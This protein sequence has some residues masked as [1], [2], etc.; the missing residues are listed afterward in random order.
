MEMI[1][2]YFFLVVA[3]LFLSVQP[4][5]IPGVKTVLANN[6]LVPRTKSDFSQ[7]NQTARW[8]AGHPKEWGSEDYHYEISPPDPEDNFN[9]AIAEDERVLALSNQTH[10]KLIDLEKNTTASIFSLNVPEKKFV[11]ALSL[12]TAADGGYNLFYGFGTYVYDTASTIF[13]Q[14]LGSDLQPMGDIIT[15]QG[16]IGAISKQGRLA[17]LDGYVY[18]LSTTN[19]TPVA[20][21]MGQTYQTG[22]SFGPDGVY[23][24][25]VNWQAQTADLWNSTS[26]EKIFAFPLTNSQNWATSISPNGDYVA[27]GLGSAANKVQIY[28]LRNLTA[29]PIEIKD[30]NNWPRFVEWS[31]TS[32]QVAIGDVPRLRVYDVPSKEIAQTWE[33][34]G[35]EGTYQ[36]PPTG[37]S[38]S[39]SGFVY[40]R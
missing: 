13:R 1:S 17:T 26:G 20:T 21:L 3:S 10:A 9:S 39:L 33:V 31:P 35:Y 36:F 40:F 5:A 29:A 11:V 2:T 23:L 8:A 16:G 34:D 7:H 37:T 19:S 4:A 27:F 25:S 30:L 38:T 24:S 6:I 14:R 18:D 15:Y 32:Q 12:R 22:M 28:Q